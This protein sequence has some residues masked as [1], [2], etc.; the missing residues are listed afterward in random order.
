MQLQ[1]NERRGLCGICPAGCWVIVTYS[2]DG[3]MA[4]IRADESSP[5]GII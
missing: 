3:K 2:A 4:S 5:L 1:E